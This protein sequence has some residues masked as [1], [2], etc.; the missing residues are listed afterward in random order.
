[1]NLRPDHIRISLYNPYSFGQGAPHPLTKK[2]VADYEQ[3]KFSA[4][5]SV[6]S[7]QLEA[8]AVKVMNAAIREGIDQSPLMMELEDALIDDITRLGLVMDKV[9]RHFED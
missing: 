5:V 8:L 6:N 3:Y 7:R 4:G 2:A 1:M 9:V